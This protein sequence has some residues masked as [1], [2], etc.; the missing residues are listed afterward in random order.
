MEICL[1]P[2]IVIEQDGSRGDLY[3]WWQQRLE[4]H[5]LALITPLGIGGVGRVCKRVSIEAWERESVK[6]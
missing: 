2:T 6:A 1:A 5:R 4:E 3:D